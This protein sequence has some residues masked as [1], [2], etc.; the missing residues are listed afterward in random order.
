M[1]FLF[2]KLRRGSR[3]SAVQPQTINSE[4]PKYRLIYK[5][6]FS[7]C[8]ITNLKRNKSIT[9]DTPEKLCKVLH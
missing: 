5:M 2:F 7:A 1:Y 4:V 6:G 8:T 3:R 9:M